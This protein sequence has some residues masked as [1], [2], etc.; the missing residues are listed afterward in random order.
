MGTDIHA[1]I[2][3][4]HDDAWHAYMF[5]NKYYGKYEN[6]PMLTAKLPLDRDYDMFGILANVRNGRGFA[7]CLLGDGFVPMSDN[8]GIPIDISPE[9]TDVLSN[10]HSATWVSLVEILT[11]DWTRNVNKYGVVSAV[12]FE[13]WDRMKEWNPGPSSFCGGVSGGLTRHI[14]EAEMRTYVNTQK[15]GKEWK[16]AI[17]EFDPN[18][19]CQITWNESYAKSGEQLWTKVLPVMLKLATEYGQENVRMI[20]D[21][22]S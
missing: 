20:M 22:D 16:I 9:A 14:T 6:E 12:Q 1:A 4:F 2:E 11:Y 17:A 3:F 18:L 10:A 5:A 8:R 13:E 19:Y 7:G 21:F 15:S